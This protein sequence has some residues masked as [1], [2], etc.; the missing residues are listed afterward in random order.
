[1]NKGSIGSEAAEPEG[2][3]LIF[4]S[5]SYLRL[6]SCSLSLCLSLDG[7]LRTQEVTLALAS[8]MTADLNLLA[9]GFPEV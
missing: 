8:E 4:L 7:N 9:V 6:P 3:W 2:H 5:E 1:M